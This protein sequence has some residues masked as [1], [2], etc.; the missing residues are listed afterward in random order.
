MLGTVPVAFSEVWSTWEGGNS[1]FELPALQIQESST[2]TRTLRRFKALKSCLPEVSDG[3]ESGWV[4]FVTSA[5]PDPM[6]LET[7]VA[8]IGKPSVWQPLPSRI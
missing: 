3:W 5:L 4:V 2:P 8:E 1:N 6:E 7:E